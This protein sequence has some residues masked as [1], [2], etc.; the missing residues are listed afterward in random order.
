MNGQICRENDKNP[1]V[2]PDGL[3]LHLTSHNA[4]SSGIKPENIVF[5]FSHS[6]V[7]LEQAIYI[8]LKI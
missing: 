4:G 7:F 3:Q 5:L 6:V 1:K 2:M 8:W